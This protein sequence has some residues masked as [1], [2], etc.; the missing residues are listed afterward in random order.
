MNYVKLYEPF[1]GSWQLEKELGQ[2]RLGKV[3]KISKND[4]DKKY[5]S[6]LKIISITP[7]NNSSDFDTINNELETLSSFNKNI[8]NYKDHSIV[9]RLDDTGYDILIRMDYLDNLS[10]FLLT[11]RLTKKDVIKLGINILTALEE[12]HSRD[13]LHKNINPNTIFLNNDGIFFLG[14]FD[15][16]IKSS[17]LLSESCDN[18]NYFYMAPEVFNLGEFS[19]G[20]DIYSLGIVLYKLLNNC[21]LPF[22]EC[23][24]S[25]LKISLFKRLS[26][27]NIPFPC[28]D[29]GTLGKIIL[30][31]ISF[32]PKKRYSDATQMKNDLFNFLFKFDEPDFF[33]T[34]IITPISPNN[35]ASGNN[36]NGNLIEYVN[37]K[38]YL[39]NLSDG[40]KI[41][42][43][44]QKENLYKKLSDDHA[45]SIK[46]YKGH[47]YFI[48]KSDNDKIYSMNTN[49]SC[50]K[51]ILNEE[52]T[53]LVFYNDWI[54]YTSYDNH[55]F[56]IK[57][58]GLD[59]MCI[60]SDKSAYVTIYK[61][62][63]YYSNASDNNSIYKFDINNKHTTKLNDIPSCFINIYKEQIFYSLIN[64]N[65][66]CR[67]ELD[68]TGKCIVSNIGAK[69]INVYKD[70]IYFSN[71]QDYNNLYK[72]KIDGLNLTKLNND[73]TEQINILNDWIYYKNSSDNGTLYKIRIDGKDKSKVLPIHYK[74]CL[75]L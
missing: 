56:R 16:S 75:F 14:N 36:I 64:C 11:K 35:I 69:F 57:P 51:I 27:E 9:K 4:W 28:N 25:N 29:N 68:G 45:D 53:S 73:Y 18:S 13:I 71:T 22:A 43:I 20:S 38:T 48:N 34:N 31:A 61:D 32:D 47:I 66:I 60:H 50:K 42:K 59:K 1:F 70:Y 21:K 33:I 72:I 19:K 65:K 5:E 52:A 39:I 55:I 6:I 26:S 58:D 10:N 62:E 54:Y 7:D 74:N 12:C 17:T 24:D 23:H 41:Y 2:D 67:M 8:L 37:D 40:Q 63:I 46:Y 3:Y 30:K 15:L 44:N 49:G